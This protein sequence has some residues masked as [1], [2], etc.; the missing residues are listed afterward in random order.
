MPQV[1]SFFR[2]EQAVERRLVTLR[3]APTLE[4][5][6]PLGASESLFASLRR[7][8]PTNVARVIALEGAPAPAVVLDA[9][10][11]L[12]A[13]HPLLRARIVA[14]ERPCFA[15]DQVAEPTL[16]LIERGDD[17]HWRQVLE[18]ALNTPLAQQAGSHCRLYYVYADRGR[19]AELILVADHTI[20][21]GVS[22]NQLCDEL[23]RGCVQPLVRPARPRLPVLD[24]LLPHFSAGTRLRHFAGSLARLARSN[25]SRRVHE[26]RPSAQGTAYLHSELSR[27][28]T[29]A[30]LAH[31]RL[32]RTTLTGALM[33]ATLSVVRS[34]RDT[35]PR[36]ALSVPID[37]RPR[38]PER[39]PTAE[40]LGNY[41]S[42]AYLTS[43]ASE[44]PWAL[45]RTL[46]T[47]LERNVEAE[48]L[49]STVGLIYSWGRRLLR[50]DRPPNAHVM[51]SNTGIVPLSHDYGSVH[52]RG[53]FGADSAPML[54]ADFA[55]FCNTFDGRLR[56]NLVFSERVASRAEAEAVLHGVC[57]YLAAMALR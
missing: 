41:T 4:A 8:T 12:H 11:L 34:V 13:R 54:S 36:L 23:L 40:D 53:F 47:E 25:L 24:R 28:E 46:K 33:A 57:S 16:E 44:A 29:S 2:A 17:G 14:A 6:A 20:C 52:V 49:L 7:F 27:S 1:Q 18:Q 3:R 50:P 19:R 43:S 55:F 35:A 32:Q 38:I 21:D 10:R 37:L 39:A 56:L 42:V 30:L 45:A 26:A 48:R 9:L 5:T 31:A 22:M 15:Y 51:L